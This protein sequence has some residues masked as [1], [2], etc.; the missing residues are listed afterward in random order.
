MTNKQKRH[1]IAYV[2]TVLFMLLLFLLLWFITLTAFE[3]EEEEGVEVAFGEVA[4]AGGYMAEQSEAV[5]MPAPE[6][7][8]PQSASSPSDNDLMTQEDEESLALRREQE[9]KERERREAEAAEK[10]RQREEQARLEAERQAREAAEAAQRAKEAEAVAKANQFGSLFG[11]TGNT[12]GSGSSQGSG[13][14]GNPVG[15][16][17][18]GERDAR[19][20]G[21]GH[22]NTRDGKIPEPTC[23]FQH[24]GVVVVKIRIDK[25]G[26]VINA[27]NTAGTNTSDQQMIQCAINAIKNTKWTAGEGVAEGTITYTFNVK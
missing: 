21:L 22:R 11:Q 9:R 19:I 8:A 12:S 15:H 6:P 26:N 20:K 13:Q 3:P 17:S 2:G 25:D 27:V 1:I 5:P 23:E 18:V 10:Q 4:D 24:Y 16:G 7:A 14:R